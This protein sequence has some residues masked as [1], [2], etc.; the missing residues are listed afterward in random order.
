MSGVVGHLKAVRM[1]F[2]WMALDI[3]E[4]RADTGHLSTKEHGA[5]LLLTMHY[6]ATGRLPENDAQL[7]RICSLTQAEF[8]RVKPTLQALFLPGWKHKRI[9]EELEKAREISEARSTAGKAGVKAKWGD[10]KI[11]GSRSER[12][13]AARKK[14]THKPEEWQALM[15]FCGFN[16]VRCGAH[17]VVKDHIQPIYQGGSDS[18]ENLQPLCRGCNA[19]KG[20]DTSDLRPEGWRDAIKCLANASQNASQTPPPSPLPSPSK[21]KNLSCD[22]KR[23]ARSPPRHGKT[24]RAGGRVYVVKGTPEWEAYADDYRRLRG[25][26][27]NVNP[28]GGRWFKTLGEA[29]IG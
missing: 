23:E 27:P 16:C 2:R 25:I 9:E 11:E 5:Y 26:E 10:D 24:N 17:G 15:E 7:A 19:S 14:G 28:H 20:A 12:L 13:A 22:A 18:I 1:K 6:W 21:I 3:P 29:S 4:Y 8:R